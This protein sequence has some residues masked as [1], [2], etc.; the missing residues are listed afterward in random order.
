M[1]A[2]VCVNSIEYC[3]YLLEILSLIAGRLF[4]WL[5]NQIKA[6][7]KLMVCE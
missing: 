3:A 2:E 1:W 5:N 4:N 6:S 7:L